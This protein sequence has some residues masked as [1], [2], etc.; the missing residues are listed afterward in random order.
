MKLS[1]FY[2][3]LTSVFNS[4]GL[5]DSNVSVEAYDQKIDTV[6]S[7]EYQ[8]SVYMYDGKMGMHVP[9]YFD[10]PRNTNFLLLINDG[11]M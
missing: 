11:L 8:Y 9:S 3:R 2:S 7:I 1:Y 10:L 5:L 4:H 6:P